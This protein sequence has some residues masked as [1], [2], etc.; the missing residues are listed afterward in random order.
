MRPC[1]GRDRGFESRR[2]RQ[3][4]NKK[5]TPKWVVFCCFMPKLL[6][7]IS[8]IL[9]TRRELYESRGFIEPAIRSA[10][11][12][13]ATHMPRFQHEAARRNTRY[14]GDVAHLPAHSTPLRQA[15]YIEQ[16]WQ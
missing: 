6:V 15:V 11:C 13:S 3:M 9:I 8:P 7:I 10:Y 16:A 1:Q 12:R 4:Y 5:S 14:R 2:D